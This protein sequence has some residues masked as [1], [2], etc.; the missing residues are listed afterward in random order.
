[1]WAAVKCLAWAGV[2]AGLALYPLIWHHPKRVPRPSP[3]PPPRRVSSVER[4]GHRT[5]SRY[6]GMTPKFFTKLAYGL[7]VKQ[8]PVIV[9][10]GPPASQTSLSTSFRIVPLDRVLI[11]SIPFSQFSNSQTSSSFPLFL[12]SP[13]TRSSPVTTH[14]F[15]SSMVWRSTIVTSSGCNFCDR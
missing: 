7:G 3:S 13:Q 5:M 6:R 1:M 4:S 9:P 15:A 11:C 8:R 2:G 10:F 12:T 14:G